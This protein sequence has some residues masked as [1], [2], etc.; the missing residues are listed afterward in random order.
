MNQIIWLFAGGIIGGLASFM[1]KTDGQQ[2]VILNFLVGIIG[3][4]HGGQGTSPLVGVGATN[5]DN[6]SMPALLASFA[7]AVVLL[8]I[9]NLFRP[10][11]VR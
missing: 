8:A 3:S 4:M 6:F 2:G 5:K 11:T 10:S 7:G 1:T 9:V